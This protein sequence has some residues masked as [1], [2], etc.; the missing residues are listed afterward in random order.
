[1]TP[2]KYLAFWIVVMLLSSG[3]IGVLMWQ[4]HKIIRVLLEIVVI[5]GGK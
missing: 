5:L 2:T 1:M 3:L 4:L